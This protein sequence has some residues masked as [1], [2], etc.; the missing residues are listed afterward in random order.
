MLTVMHM[1]S[2]LL[3]VGMY[4]DVLCVVVDVLHV[5]VGVLS[6]VVDCR[7]VVV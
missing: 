1:L 2:L 5:G 7:T 4:G 3:C 6:V